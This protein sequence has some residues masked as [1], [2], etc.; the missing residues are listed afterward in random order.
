MPI[1]T[2]EQLERLKEAGESLPERLAKDQPARHLWR[3]HRSDDDPVLTFFGH[4]D[5]VAH[6]V[7]GMPNHGDNTMA[8]ILAC[9]TETYGLT[10]QR[11]T[12][13]R[14]SVEAATFKQRPDIAAK[15]VTRGYATLLGTT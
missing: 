5:E 12:G 10:R 4:L 1:P 11:L 2:R 14:L 7:V 13:W 8:S 9:L 3:Y 6:D 15:V